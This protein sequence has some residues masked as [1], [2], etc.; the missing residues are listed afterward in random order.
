MRD[1]QKPSNTNDSLSQLKEALVQTILNASGDELRAE[2]K[3]NGEDP[4]KYIELIESVLADA[5]SK[6]ARMRLDEAKAQAAAFKAQKH[7]DVVSFDKSAAKAQPGIID[8]RPS[9]ETMLAARKGKQ[10][11]KRDEDALSRARIKL[12]KLESKSHEDN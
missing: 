8:T 12:Q 3:E 4:E 2:I 5:K 10:L 1:P 7:G 11:S 9:V 6:C